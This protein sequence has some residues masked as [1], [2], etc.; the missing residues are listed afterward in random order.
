M[1]KA[2]RKKKQELVE[3]AIVRIVYGEDQHTYAQVLVHPGSCRT[4]WIRPTS[5]SCGR[6]SMAPG[7]SV[8]GYTLNPV[9]Y[10]YYGA[11]D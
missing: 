6:R 5:G 4:C 8:P 1:A 3:G 11:H 9:R 2:R 10:W 7:T